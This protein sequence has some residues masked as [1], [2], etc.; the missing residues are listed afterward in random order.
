MLFLF[1]FLSTAEAGL[2]KGFRVNACAGIASHCPIGQIGFAYNT[3]RFAVDVG[4]FGPMPVGAHAGLQV[5]PSDN[6]KNRWFL[7]AMPSEEE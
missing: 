3:K 5:Y 1:S 4:G 6:E 2:I 7:G